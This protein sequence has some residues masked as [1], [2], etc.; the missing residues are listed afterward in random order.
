MVRTIISLLLVF[1]L[2]T[3][4][5]SEE[6]R[7][8]TWNVKD[9]FNT[10][11]VTSRKT[12][13]KSMADTLRPDVL[14]IQEITSQRVAEKIRD[15]MGLDGYYVACSDFVQSDSPTRNA[16]EV[17][18][19]SKWPMQ[20]VIEF[21]PT[22][23]NNDEDDPEELPLEPLLKIGI[24]EV[25]TARGYLWARIDDIK[26]T[27]AVVHL[28]S[29][30]GRV[31]STDKSNAKKRELVAAAVANGVN[32]DISYFPDYS[33]IALGDMNVGHSDG[34]KNGTDIDDDCYK[35]CED[36]DL[37]DETHALLGAGLVGG[38][39]MRNVVL[40]RTEATYPSFPSS[41]IDN[42][43]IAGEKKDEFSEAVV[44]ADTF[45]SDHLPVMTVLALP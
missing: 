3:S 29:S 38:L 42:I 4:L 19:I 16:F 9:I 25:G 18:I 5:R 6:V 2:G 24:E 41:P 28:K 7:I 8:V 43:Y 15:E 20:Q 45:G 14:V 26:M 31:G 35:N 27:V 36:R 30:L 37:Y 44:G 22:V 1:S 40:S 21:D 39:A 13:L 32:E 33:F 23:D 10:G 12:D 34:K 17:A 11:D